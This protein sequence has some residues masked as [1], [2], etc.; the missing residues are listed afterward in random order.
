M[1]R[2][3]RFTF[4][5]ATMA[6]GLVSFVACGGDDSDPSSGTT[7]TGSL[8]GIC[9]DQVVIQ[10]DWF[11]E[12]EHGT[13]Y[14]LLGDDYRIDVDT[15]RVTGSLIDADG[16]DTGVDVQIRAGG[17][18]IGGTRVVEAMATDSDITL[19]FVNTD[20]AAF[21]HDTIATLAVVGT[22]EKNP[23]MLMWDPETYP[24]VKSIA[25]LG[26]Q[27]I[28]I[29]VFSAGSFLDV[30]VAT[31]VLQKSQLDPSYDGS[32]ARFIAEGGRIAQQGFAS[33]EPYL[34]EK[35]FTEWGRPVSYQL[36]HDAGFQIYAQPLAIRAADKDALAPCLKKL[37]PLVQ[38]AS[39]AYLKDGSRANQIIV[40]A[41][42]K[43]DTFWV[44][45]QGVADFS[46]G[47][48][49]ELGLVGN[50]DDDLVDNF[51][52]D[53]VNQ[54]LAQLRDA[55]LDVPADL[56]AADIYTNEFIDPSIGL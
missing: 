56:T 11:P 17:P 12:A 26:R 50:G 2:S 28:T 54:V 51:D 10:T 34:Y 1:L 19:G 22:L 41:V 27:G 45:E 7:A 35:T 15:K 46:T 3:R 42:E 30:F 52:L 36:L 24:D 47:V 21:N 13:V 9:P 29:N 5:V 49:R 38:R 53:R 32:P 31:G 37:V 33:A 39:V 44:Y 8:S 43:Y 55:G 16:S 4:T 40:E 6:L 18:A 20:S 48:Q 25:D 14:Q 23:Q